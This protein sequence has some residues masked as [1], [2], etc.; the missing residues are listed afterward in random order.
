MFMMFLRSYKRRE[1]ERPPLSDLGGFKSQRAATWNSVRSIVQSQDG[2]GARPPPVHTGTSAC[3]I[4][5][6]LVYCLPLAGM[7]GVG[8]TSI[9]QEGL[10]QS[11][12]LDSA[13]GGRSSVD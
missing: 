13:A 2:W 7:L 12:T 3:A 9:R 11:N 8:M 6:N 4:M 10:M 1:I 5:G